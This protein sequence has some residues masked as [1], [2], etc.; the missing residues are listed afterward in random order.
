MDDQLNGQG[1]DNAVAKQTGTEVDSNSGTVESAA[2]TTLVEV[3]PGLAAVFGEV[4]NG[5]ELLNLDL[6]PSFDRAELSSVLGSVGTWSTLGGNLVVAAES[7]QGL[8]RLDDA[9]MALLQSGAELA[10][11]DGANLGAIFKN[12][13]LIAQARLIPAA[14]TPA[15]AIAAIGPALAL[16]AIESKIDEVS[17][18]VNTNI[19][20]TTQTLKAIRFEQ[21]SELEGLAKTMDSTIKEIRELGTVTE[22]IWESVAPQRTAVRHQLNLYRLNVADHIKEIKKLE[23]RARREYLES[24]A[25]AIVFDSN[26]LL[27]SLKVF[28]EYEAIRASIARYRGQSDEDE[29]KQFESIVEKT[30]AEIETSLTEIQQLIESSSGNCKSSRNFRRAAIPFMGRWRESRSTKLTS[31][32]I[33]EAINPL[34]EKLQSAPNDLGFRNRLCSRG[35]S[36]WNRISKSCDGSFSAMRNWKQ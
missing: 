23:G 3:A 4:P 33:L 22:S 15:M 7:L 21:W 14:M 17:D 12:G 19:Q 24:N 16:A 11:K 10:F 1:A 13:E 35:P 5:L 32:Q 26:A 6:V 29:A 28:A 20:L 25:E 8:Y 30:P 27:T 9:T 36:S 2:S 18:L 34:A 31:Q